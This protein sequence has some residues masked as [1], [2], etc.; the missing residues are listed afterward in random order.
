MKST[1]P[2]RLTLALLAA[3]AMHSPA[4]MAQDAPQAA[5]SEP[6]AE[7]VSEAVSEPASEPATEPASEPTSEP[8][9]EA[10]SS[11]PLSEPVAEAAAE[12]ASEVPPP[13]DPVSMETAAPEPE[14]V[15]E[16]AQD[17]YTPEPEP[18]KSFM[19]KIFPDF[20]MISIASPQREAIARKPSHFGSYCH[21][22]PAGNAPTSF[23][24]MGSVAARGWDLDIDFPSPNRQLFR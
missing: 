17:S 21:P 15:S 23:A 8:A 6:P 12:T 10:A 5:P 20:D 14:V 4:L 19:Q 1:M 22:G 11:E 2:R 9:T 16:L 24:S 3:A 13:S 7:S 18:E